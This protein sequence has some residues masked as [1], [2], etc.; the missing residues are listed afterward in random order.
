MKVCQEL[1]SSQQQSKGRSQ[2]NLFLSIEIILLD[3]TEVCV[4]EQHQTDPPADALLSSLCSAQNQEVV[5]GADSTFKVCICH[6][7]CVG[8][9][10][11]CL[12]FLQTHEAVQ[13]RQDSRM[14]FSMP[15]KGHA[16][17][18]QC[19]FKVTLKAAHHDALSLFFTYHLY[20]Q[21]LSKR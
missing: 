11:F 10:G 18:Y 9:G 5:S 12:S 13:H 15:W 21:C 20:F 7:R 4:E 14:N 8:R 2:P 16:I 17:T 3:E 6:H 1:Y 19:H